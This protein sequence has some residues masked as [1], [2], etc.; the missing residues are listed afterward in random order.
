[1]LIVGIITIVCAG[2][3]WIISFNKPTNLELVLLFC[4]IIPGMNLIIMVYF[5]VTLLVAH[6]YVGD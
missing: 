6:F 1:M 3:R 5:L 4:C 2:L